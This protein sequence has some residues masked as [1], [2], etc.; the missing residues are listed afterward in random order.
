MADEPAI[1][2]KQGIAFTHIPVAFGAPTEDHLEAL[3]AALQRLQG[4]KVLVHCQVNMRA[5]TLVFLYRTIKRQ[6][7]PAI[8]WEA[9][10]RVWVPGG[11]WRGLVVDQLAKH[12][13]K[14]EPF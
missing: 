1:L 12:G 6:E 7:D 13:I 2:A 11:A 5:S 4:R 8:A 14:F 9:V 3:S 10:A